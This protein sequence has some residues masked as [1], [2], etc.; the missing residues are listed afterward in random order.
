MAEA[1]ELPGSVMIPAQHTLRASPALK[2]QSIERKQHFMAL[3]ADEGLA[4]YAGLKATPKKS[5]LSEYSSGADPRKV[6][7]ILTAW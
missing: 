1:V 5:F 4:L 6:M 2:L 7:Q 3:V